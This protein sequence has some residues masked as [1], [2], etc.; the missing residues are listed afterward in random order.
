MKCEVLIQWEC[1]EHKYSNRQKSDLDEERSYAISLDPSQSHSL[2][3][4]EIWKS[5]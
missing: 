5:A 2:T 3:T 4:R 1:T